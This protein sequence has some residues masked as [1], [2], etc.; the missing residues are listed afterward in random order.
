MDDFNP[1]DLFRKRKGFSL[2]Q[3]DLFEWLI[4][5]NIA[6]GMLVSETLRRQIELEGYLKNE[7]PDDEMVSQ[8]LKEITDRIADEAT[9]KKNSTIANLYIRDKDDNG[10]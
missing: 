6:T 2:K 4:A 5:Q 7:N 1:D 10:D 3:G 9:N 8:R